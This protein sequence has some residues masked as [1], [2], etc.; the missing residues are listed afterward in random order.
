M[1]A[2]KN[3]AV[4]FFRS[5]ERKIND[6]FDTYFLRVLNT[7]KPVALVSIKN[8]LDN[9]VLELKRDW[10]Q[11]LELVEPH[12]H[13]YKRDNYRELNDLLNNHCRS[14]PFITASGGDESKMLAM[15][16]QRKHSETVSPTKKQEERLPIIC[17]VFNRYNNELQELLLELMPPAPKQKLKVEPIK[18]T[19]KITWLGSPE[20]FG[21]IFGKMIVGGYI[22]LPNSDGDK[23]VAKIAEN[24]LNV[25]DIRSTK[26]NKGQPTTKGNLEKAL[27]NRNSLSTKMRIEIPPINKM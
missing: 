8:H 4:I 21:L 20:Q 25:F 23:S 11:Y 3:D 17:P 14:F 5:I 6:T 27:S 2:K 26:K 22:D 12:T 9:S 13:D 18:T 16:F 7:D 10:K 24:F 19:E 1:K 15:A